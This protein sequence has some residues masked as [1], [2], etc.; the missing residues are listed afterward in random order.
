MEWSSGGQLPKSLEDGIKE[1]EKVWVWSVWAEPLEDRRGDWTDTLKKGMF[2]K[3]IVNLGQK[4]FA[5]LYG[6]ILV[7]SSRVIQ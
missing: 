1:K 4:N 2:G 5:T 7:T 6:K 3:E